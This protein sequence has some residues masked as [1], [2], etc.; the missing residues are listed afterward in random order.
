MLNRALITGVTGQDGS[1]LAE[2]LLLEGWEVHGLARRTSTYNASRI[3]SILT[4]PHFKLIRGDVTDAGFMAKIIRENEYHEV[5]NL[6]AQSFVGTSYDEPTHTTQVNLNGCLN[7]LEAI[8][9]LPEKMRPKFYQASTS[10]MFGTSYSMHQQYDRFG[11]IE[12]FDY[13]EISPLQIDAGCRYHE[14]E[15]WECQVEF[16]HKLN[17]EKFPHEAWQNEDTPFLPTS[18]YAVAKLAA[19]HLVKVYR[20]A[21]G[22][23]ACSGI[24]F[25]HES[26]RRGEEFVTRKITKYIGK[27]SAKGLEKVGT[28]KL[29]N[30]EA[31]RD[32]GHANDYVRGQVLMLRHDTPDDY[33]LATGKT[34]SVR[35]FLDAA[36]GFFN[37]DWKKFI[38]VSPSEMRPSDV[39][40]L[41]GDAS[42][43]K[44]ILG[45]EPHMSFEKLV[46]GMVISDWE[47]AT[48]RVFQY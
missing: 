43:A 32:W 21:Y 18:P 47:A 9:S 33:V 3:E 34:H 7:C 29:G 41:R 25:N 4:H 40:Y 38:E 42:K 2:Q 46:H 24:L 12:H 31:C 39:P 10:E 23:F 17:G 14:K 11:T 5:Y 8:R 36:F 30:I 35:E 6:A 26:S 19:H 16:F 15:D 48:G 44:R 37:Q 45:W 22:L 20:E 27:L 1:F 28:L 13:R